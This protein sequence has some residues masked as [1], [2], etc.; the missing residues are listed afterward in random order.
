MD[1]NLPLVTKANLLIILSL[2]GVVILLLFIK[3]IFNIILLLYLAIILGEGLRPLVKVFVGFGLRYSFAVLT[4]FCLIF[5]I[6]ACLIGVFINPI[7]DQFES[8][9]KQLPT[10]TALAQSYFGKEEIFKNNELLSSLKEQVSSLSSS[11]ASFIILLPKQIFNFFFNVVIVFFISYFWLMG[12]KRYS[13]NLLLLCPAKYRSLLKT[14]FSDISQCIAAYLRG[15]VIMMICIGLIT[16]LVDAMLGLPYAFLLGVAAGL[17]EAI[18]IVGPFIGA[19]PAV[20]LAFLISPTH[21][22]V[23]GIFYLVLQ[24]IEGNIL[25]PQIMNKML[26]LDPLVILLSVL[27]GTTLFGLYGAFLSV[28]TAAIIQIIFNSLVYPHLKQPNSTS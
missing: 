9:I 7:L 11:L 28:P 20:I 19:V 27:I 6:L 10:Y 24:Q 25:V 4:V 1:K 22:L 23:V 21:A 13:D 3:A 2:L 5:L 14:L 12:S 8:F 26:K 16:G 17:T 18:P 15:V